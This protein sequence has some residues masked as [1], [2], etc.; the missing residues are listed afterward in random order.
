MIRTSIEPGRLLEELSLTAAHCACG[1]R[2]FVGGGAGSFA[3]EVWPGW[4]GLRGACRREPGGRSDRPL[5]LVDGM[6]LLIVGIAALAYVAVRG[7]SSR[8][9]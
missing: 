7:S 6:V 3:L 4:L 5:Q 2:R 9:A 1:C 8:S